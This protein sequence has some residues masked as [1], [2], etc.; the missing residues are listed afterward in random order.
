M[1]TVD[2]ADQETIDPRHTPGP[3]V[4]AVPG[5]RLTLLAD[6]DLARVGVWADLPG[7][8]PSGIG[9]RTPVFTDGRPL[10]NPFISRRP[11]GIAP[12]ADGGAVLDVR[13][14][15]TGVVADGCAVVDTLR[16]DAASLELGVVLALGE[17]TVLLLE[18]REGLDPAPDHGL[19]GSS[20]G[21][22]RV[23]RQ[24]SLVADLDVPVLIRGESGVG[25]ELV[26]RAIH[27]A[28]RRHGGPWVAVNM[29]GVPPTLAAS[30]LF[31]HVRGAFTGAV[32]AHEGHFVHAHQGTLF[33]DEVGDTPA[34]VQPLLLRVLETGDV[35]PVGAR[36][37]ASVNVRVISA[38][39]AFLEGRADFRVPLLHRLAGFQIQVP[40]LR[41][42]RADIA[43][44]CAHF[45]TQELHTLGLEDRLQP[46]DV[47][48]PWLPAALMVRLV[49]ADWPGNVRQLR[50]VVRQ[51]VITHR[52]RPQLD[53][54]SAV[55]D[56]VLGH[57]AA[58]SDPVPSRPTYRHV[59]TLDDDALIAALEAHSFRIKA[60]AEALGVSRTALY[61]RVDRCPRVRKA[62][63]L[64]A[65]EIAQAAALHPTIVD[66]AHALR[67][68]L[69]ALKRRMTALGVR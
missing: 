18:R 38:T 62:G 3:N 35:E 9:R 60:T 47:H 57:V 25:K 69:Q 1:P 44:L 19:V 65:E 5:L 52:D 31:G 20:A 29:A 4:E 59:D 53:R 22:D 51:L 54:W 13:L 36:R 14:T 49:T 41:T 58:P 23:R 46:V 68:S 7:D 64:T 21:L 55:I 48:Q 34:A 24:I 43:Q 63:D 27:E 42:R 37:V 12:T 6:G 39:D 30:T 2:P 56:G 50:N 8:R 11:V 10:D 17:H 40:P 28:S 45:A 26:A 67:V 32:A 61:A 16:L 33:M 66:Q 15:P